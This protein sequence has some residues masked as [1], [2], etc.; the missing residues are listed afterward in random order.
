MPDL[1]GPVLKP[2]SRIQFLGQW[3]S[4][5]RPCE[6]RAASFVRLHSSQ[7]VLPARRAAWSRRRSTQRIRQPEN[8]HSGLTE[9]C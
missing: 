3:I 8:G 4:W 6:R 7:P 2:G 5:V 1:K 9:F